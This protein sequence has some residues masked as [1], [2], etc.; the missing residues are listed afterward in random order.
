S[1]EGDPPDPPREPPFSLTPEFP[2]SFAA[3]PLSPCA[4]GRNRLAAAV[5]PSPSG[6]EF[7]SQFWHVRNPGDVEPGQGGRPTLTPL[8]KG[9][10]LVHG[11]VE[12][13]R[14]VRLVASDPLHR[15]LGKEEP[16]PLRPFDLGG[17]LP[18]LLCGMGRLLS[19]LLFQ[20]LQLSSRFLK[21]C[22]NEI[23]DIASLQS[24]PGG[25]D[26]AQLSGGPVRV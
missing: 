3:R 1:I 15:R 8:L 6:G 2:E 5:R 11:L 9:L 4:Q 23:G 18:L 16:L 14:E 22:G 12:L 21:G 24:R 19:Q 26:P 17:P 25:E 10:E 13:P 7:V 20:K